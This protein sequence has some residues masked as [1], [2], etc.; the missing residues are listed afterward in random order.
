MTCWGPGGSG[1]CQSCG[2]TGPG[3]EVRRIAVEFLRVCGWHYGNGD[4]IGGDPYEALL[5]PQC[6][7][8]EKRRVV[9]KPGIDQDMLPIDWAQC[10][11]TEHSQ[12]GHTI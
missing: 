11:V 7:K 2:K 6:S 4:T 3:H 5:C 1:I 9:K 12:G 10:Q 8:D